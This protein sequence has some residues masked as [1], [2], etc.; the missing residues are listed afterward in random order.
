M[1][2]RIQL[3]LPESKQA[4]RE[5]VCSNVQIRRKDSGVLWQNMVLKVTTMYN[6]F[7][8]ARRKDFDSFQVKSS[9]CLRGL[10]LI[11]LI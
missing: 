9:K 1:E 7:Y 11:R 10:R 5:N 2:V 6:S 8:K 3:C 4:F